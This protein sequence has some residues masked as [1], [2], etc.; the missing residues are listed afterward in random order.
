MDW[1]D[2]DMILDYYRGLV[3]G[4]SEYVGYSESTLKAAIVREAVALPGRRVIEV[5]AGPNPIVPLTLA[6]AGREVH[7][8][9]ISPDFCETARLNAERAG[10]DIAI[11]C[12]PAHCVPLPDGAADVVIMT[13]VLEHIPNDLELPTLRE[14]RRL[15]ADTGRLLISVPNADSWFARWNGW[16]N[17]GHVPE[18]D[19]HLREY[20]VRRLTARL[21][22]A[23]FVV[24][25]PIRVAATDRP[26]RE[27][28]AAW[29]IDRLSF[30]AEWGMKAAAV[31]RPV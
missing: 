24:E 27:T 12:A 18:N 14:L 3:A 20:T 5:G 22:D 11:T 6:G 1:T 30:R 16:R 10:V 31:A 25:R 29:V 9:E 2:T 17:A 26:F 19:E 28:R 23:G 8:V 4:G 21:G 7:I 13:E 15:V